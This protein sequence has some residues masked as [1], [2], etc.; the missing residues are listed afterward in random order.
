MGGESVEAVDLDRRGIVGDRWFAVQ[1]DD[2]YYASGKATKRFRRRDAVFDYRATTDAAGAV[3]VAG[4]SGSW[5]AGD[6]AL[7]A[8]LS[9]TMGSAVHVV[10][11]SDVPHQ[12]AGSV[13]LIGTATLAWCAQQLGVDADPRR[14]RVNVVFESDEPFIEDSWVGQSVRIGATVLTVAQRI[15][16]CRTID[17]A[18]DGAAAERRWLAPLGEQRDL[19]VAIYAD[20][21]NPGRIAVGDAVWA[22]PSP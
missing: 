18:Q 9:T 17:V 4:T 5:L 16:R 21:A 14:L 13:S 7:D 15:Q 6:P 20:V 2:G 8:E 1:D 10:P 19:R 11:E 3:R 22:P 12:D